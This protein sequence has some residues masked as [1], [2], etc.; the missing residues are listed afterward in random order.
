MP[1][2]KETTDLWQGAEKHLGYL[3]QELITVK[4]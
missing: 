3:E 4:P 2:E 1:E